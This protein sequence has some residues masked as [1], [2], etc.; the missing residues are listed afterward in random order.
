MNSRRCREGKARQAG[1]RG[2][3]EQGWKG[4]L[5]SSGDGGDDDGGGDGRSGGERRKID[6][7]RECE[8]NVCCF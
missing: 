7:V 3:G 8:G 2:F 1:G 6:A 4:E 5:G